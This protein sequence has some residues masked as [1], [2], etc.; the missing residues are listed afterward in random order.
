[1]KFQ[2]ALGGALAAA[3][4]RQSPWRA[5]AYPIK[6]AAF[7]RVFRRTWRALAAALCVMTARG[8]G[9]CA[10]R[11]GSSCRGRAWVF[12]RLRNGRFECLR[13]IL[14]HVRAVQVSATEHI[15]ISVLDEEEQNT[16]VG[17]VTQVQ[18]IVREYWPPG[19][20]REVVAL[21]ELGNAQELRTTVNTHLQADDAEGLQALLSDGQQGFA[22]ASLGF[23]TLMDSAISAAVKHGA[24]GCL[25]WVL[26]S[27]NPS[28][29]LTTRAIVR[30]ETSI[31]PRDINEALL[32]R[33]AQTVAMLPRVLNVDYVRTCRAWAV[34]IASTPLEQGQWLTQYIESNATRRHNPAARFWIPYLVQRASDTVLEA[35]LERAEDGGLIRILQAEQ[36]RRAHRLA[37][38][39][40]THARL[41][42]D[43]GNLLQG[44]P[45]MVR[46]IGELL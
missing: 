44:T 46:A 41:G 30:S 32:V 38:A 17:R 23:P 28:E 12:N 45:E 18:D 8:A 14:G 26:H 11:R 27:V 16:D 24:F 9:Y 34:Y 7:R 43:S 33:I 42:R 22:V 25:H 21:K 5:R 31:R 15:L 13:A 36:K 35:E 1:M 40:G 39:M 29:T 20:A 37:W 3:A 6:I 10:G 19:H 2:R 4:G